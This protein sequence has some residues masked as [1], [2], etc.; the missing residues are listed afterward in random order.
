MGNRLTA[1][2][3]AAERARREQGCV[4]F[5]WVRLLACF[6]A[7]AYIPTRLSIS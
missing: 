3:E 1:E 6:L 4:A 5:R 7:L 2:R